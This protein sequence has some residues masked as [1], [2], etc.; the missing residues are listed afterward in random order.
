VTIT[1]NAV[2]DAPVALADTATTDEDT[3]LTVAAPS[4]LGNDSDVEGDTLTAVLDTPPASGSLT[5]N[6]DGSYEF[7]PA[8]NS[9]DEVTFSYHAE[10]ATDSSEIVTVTITVN[11]VNDAPVALA[12]TA[13]TDEDTTLTV[14]A[15]GVLGNDSDV[16]GDTLTAV[17]DTPPASGSLTLNGDG[18]Y[19]FVPAPNMNGEVS[20]SYH[21][22]DATTSSSIVTVTIT[23]NPVVD[24]GF[25][26]WLAS[27][28]LVVN[29]GDDPD[30]DGI[31]NAVEFVIGGDPKNRSDV[32]L[33]PTIS[34]VNADPDNNTTNE[35]YLLFT[36]RRTD[37][38]KNDDKTTINVDWNTILIGSWTHAQGTA[39]VVSIETNDI[40]PGIDLVKVYI[41]KSLAVNGKLFAR[42]SVLIDVPVANSAPVGEAKNVSVDEN[43]SLPILL[44]ASD[45][46]DDLLFYQVAVDP[47]HGL[48]SGTAP[49]L[50]YTPAADYSGPDSFTFVAND[51][52]ASSARVLVSI[53]VNPVN[54]FNQWL[55]LHNLGA[56]PASDSDFDSI[57]NSVEYVIGGNPAT[58]S[59]TGFL[60]TISLV[61]ADP[62]NNTTNEDYLLFTYRRTDL[63]KND[64]KTT[65][66]VDWNTILIGSWTHAQG[67]AGVVS[68]ETNDIEP[69]IDLVKVYIPKSLAV[70][71]KLFAR[72]SV[73]IDVPVANS[74]PVG[75]AKNVSV[76]ENSSLP[77]LLT[78]SDINDD[79]LFYQVAVDPLHGLLSGTAPNLVYTPAADYSGPDSFTFV[80]NDGIAS[81]ARVLV[82]ITVNPVNKFNQWLGLHNLGASP[83]SD[84]DFDSIS[85]SVEYVIGGNPATGSETG[86]LPTIS[87]V[88]A[89]PDNNLTNE[90]YLLFTYR[91]RDLA[92]ND[93]AT[94][95]KVEWNTSF[96]GSW[97]NA[98]S[99]AGVVTKVI[100]DG[101]ATGVDLVQVYIPRA[102]SA[103]GKLFARLSV[104]IEVP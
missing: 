41:P 26:N 48:L 58:G 25:A 1:V 80:A 99:T 100:D 65:I 24:D 71:G 21:A 90:D 87:M 47:L 27:F 36:Y 7:I 56:S 60:P 40:E 28:G 101:A 102:L 85:N 70:N 84:S 19:E 23:V 35:D 8:A 44:T 79:L 37:L 93:A 76:D 12:D 11:A 22:E 9:T 61:N 14:A 39:G 13:S 67:T 92:N 64:D 53:T 54:K 33:L 31:S 55:G 43:S 77:I 10:D 98:G 86:F 45:I 96:I 29:P 83:A 15:P 88:N 72:L 34:L 73:L 97:T 103:N 38:A 57:S 5:L 89:D 78:A 66:N 94:T 75:E 46:N 6:P 59:D 49:N 42:L 52:I 3:T 95:I 81:S 4:V 74:A 104:A 50:V 30:H 18:S 68:I 91:R 69:G 17:L 2:N 16:E 62:D 32:D 63:A 20:F 51:G 82:S